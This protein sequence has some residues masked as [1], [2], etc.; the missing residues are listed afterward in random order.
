MIL[1]VV[2]GIRPIVWADPLTGQSIVT[3]VP[4]SRIGGAKDTL[5]AIGR[6]AVSYRGVVAVTQPQDFTVMLFDSLG[7]PVG[8]IGRKGEA[9][10]EFRRMSGAMIGWIGDTLWVFERSVGRLSYFQSTGEFLRAEAT[11]STLLP[12][13]HYQGP[14]DEG[15]SSSIEALAIGGGTIRGVAV[16]EGRRA[17]VWLEVG[18][19]GGLPAGALVLAA[20]GADGRYRRTLAV[21]PEPIECQRK[22]GTMV[23]VQVPLCPRSLHA[24]SPD[25]ARVAVAKPSGE[26]DYRVEVR[27][28]SLDREIFSVDLRGT[29]IAVER[30]AKDR[31]RE[32]LSGGRALPADVERWLSELPIPDRYPPFDR[33]LLGADGTVWVREP[34]RPGDS[35]RWRVF[36]AWG[37]GV[38]VASLPEGL[39]VRWARLDALWGVSEDSDGSEELVRYVLW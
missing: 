27:E 6:I 18:D 14:D 25:G 8:K 39:D 20:A 29:A 12:P 21:L 3:A 37:R 30:G 11:A 10:G 13:L 16:A 32:E 7:V 9:P 23:V 36:N 28:V 33:V 15:W 24:V 1:L 26:D 19:G 22:M 31:L 5:S 2:L 4:T 34:Q 17:P 35:Q 38:M